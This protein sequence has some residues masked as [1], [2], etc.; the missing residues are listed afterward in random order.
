VG[1]SGSPETT[2][3][4]KIA[5]SVMVELNRPGEGLGQ[6]RMCCRARRRTSQPFRAELLAGAF[7]FTK[8]FPMKSNPK[9]CNTA[10]H[11]LQDTQATE[12]YSHTA[13]QPSSL[14]AIHAHHAIEDSAPRRC[15]NTFPAAA[16]MAWDFIERK[17]EGAKQDDVFFFAR[18][19]KSVEIA[20]DIRLPVHEFSK[21]FSLFWNEGLRRGK[22]DGED[23][24]EWLECLEPAYHRAKYHLFANVLEN[25]I[26]AARPLPEN[27]THSQRIERLLWVCRE[28]AEENGDGSFF[29]GYRD[30]GRV[31]GTKNL[32][33]ARNAFLALCS[34]GVIRLESKGTNAGRKASRYRFI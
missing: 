26:C 8:G 15:V 11:A 24:D 10:T 22:L 16:S 23:F 28:L 21:A 5:R 17:G 19:I 18:A 30:A 25:A 29:I 12:P 20:T 32:Y 13:I 33:T 1:A 3:L 6:R 9:G 14:R 7:R 31:I 27:P 2:R 4:E 34:R